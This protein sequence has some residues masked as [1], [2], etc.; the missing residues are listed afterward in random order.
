MRKRVKRREQL[1]AEHTNY[2]SIRFNII[3]DLIRKYI[4]NELEKKMECCLNLIFPLHIY[5][6]ICSLKTCTYLE[7]LV[8]RKKEVMLSTVQRKCYFPLS[9]NVYFGSKV[10]GNPIY[11]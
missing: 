4:V 9:T 2:A 7:F 11:F 5:I 3:K 1:M 6:H 10:S 8:A